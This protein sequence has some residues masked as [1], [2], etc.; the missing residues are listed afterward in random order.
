MFYGASPKVF[1]YAKDLRNSLTEPEKIL[2]EK[3]RLK[4]LNGYRFKPQHPVAGFIADFYCHTARLV[5][6]IDGGYHDSKSQ[7]EFDANRTSVMN[8]FGIKIIRFRNEDVI[9]RIDFVL[10]EIKRNL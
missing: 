2:W 10:A 9:D 1:K 6:E 5:I 8:E 7:S 4:R 3:L